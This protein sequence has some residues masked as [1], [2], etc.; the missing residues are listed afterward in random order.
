MSIKHALINYDIQ[1]GS[2]G[3]SHPTYTTEPLLAGGDGAY[4]AEEWS[5][6]RLRGVLEV[7]S[8][9][10]LQRLAKEESLKVDLVALPSGDLSSGDSY[11]FVLM[12][13]HL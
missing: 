13:P 8:I 9:G 3:L 4:S 12:S 10:E 1:L 5:M 2:F 7:G 6:A 11:S